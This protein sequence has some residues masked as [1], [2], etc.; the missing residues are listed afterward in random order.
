MPIEP[1]KWQLLFEKN[2]ALGRIEAKFCALIDDV[3]C[4]FPQGRR[5]RRWRCAQNAN[6]QLDH[7]GVKVM[8]MTKIIEPAA[9]P[10]AYEGAYNTGRR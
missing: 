6:A 9:D 8:L 1:F 2:R 3:D 5:S 4:P 7:L 10:R